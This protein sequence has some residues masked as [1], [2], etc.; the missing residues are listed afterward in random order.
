M[1]DGTDMRVEEGDTGT[2]GALWLSP[3]LGTAS[4]WDGGSRLGDP[5]GAMVV[6]AHVDSFRQGLGPFAQ[7]TTMRAGDRVD[8]VSRTQRQRFEVLS[9]RNVPRSS[10]GADADAFSSYGAMRLVLITCGGP[11]DADAGGYRDNVVVVATPVAPP[12]PR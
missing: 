6:A 5:F 10:L 12:A 2:D 11:Y 1:P 3:D 7:L 8:V 4:W 9:T